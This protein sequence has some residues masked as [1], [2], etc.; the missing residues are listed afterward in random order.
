[1][2]IILFGAPGVGKGTQ[3]KILA[4]KL[5]VPH[6]STGDILR[7]AAK[8]Q[9]EMGKKAQVIM[10]RGDLVPDD[11]MVGIIKDRLDKPDCKEGFILDG[12]PRT[13]IQAAALD[14]LFEELG[15]KNFKVINIDADEHE[16]VKRLNNRR[17]CNKCGK[18]FTL[19]EIKGMSNCP[20]CNADNSFYLRDDDKEDVI[21]NRI[22]VF[23]ANTMPVLN[24]YSSRCEVIT[25]NGIGSIEDVNDSIIKVLKK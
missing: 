15:I 22:S 17:A 12:F 18:I 21:R 3:A 5:R 7:Q 23:K 25:I 11:I 4:S 8:D 24:Y 2:R 20:N 16:I 1:M 19:E 13:E 9:T 14:N 6:I 10:N